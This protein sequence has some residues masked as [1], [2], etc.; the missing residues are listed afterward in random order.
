MQW[1]HVPTGQRG[2]ARRLLVMR[3]VVV[4]SIEAFG[5]G[6]YG[7]VLGERTGNIGSMRRAKRIVRRLVRQDRSGLMRFLKG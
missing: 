4:G 7:N 1:R 3:G 6:A 5:Y 2:Y